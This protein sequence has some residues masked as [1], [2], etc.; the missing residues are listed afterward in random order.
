[1]Q[2]AIRKNNKSFTRAGR[3]LLARFPIEVAAP[4][5]RRGE[6]SC[7]ARPWRDARGPAFL[8]FALR[9][10]LIQFLPVALPVALVSL[11]VLHRALVLFGGGPRFER[12][13]ISTALGLRI[14]LPRI[15]TI[16]ARAQF[17]DHE[18]TSSN[19]HATTSMSA[20]A[21]FW[22]DSA[23]PPSRTHRQTSKR[24]QNVP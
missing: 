14:E 5:K 3:S 9:T 18:Y 2:C 15:Q 20:K 24:L 16:F 21:H 13:Q 19:L 6:R 1:M 8:G 23:M 12:A 17:A 7:A 4:L 22:L 10:L 11:E